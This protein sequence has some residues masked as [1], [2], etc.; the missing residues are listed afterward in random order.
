MLLDPRSMFHCVGRCIVG[1]GDVI[2][3]QELCSLFRWESGLHDS[4]SFVVGSDAFRVYSCQDNSDENSTRTL[5]GGP[6]LTPR[7]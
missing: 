3:A 7:P 2:D 4:P 5:C 1:H 6:T